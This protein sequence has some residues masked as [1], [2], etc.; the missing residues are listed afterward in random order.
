VPAVAVAAIDV[1][2]SVFVG[3]V[4]ARGDVTLSGP[5]PV[6]GTVVTLT[7]SDPA[8]TVAGSTTIGEGASSGQFGVS[9]RAVTT[10]TIVTISG[11]AGGETRSKGIRIIPAGSGLALL[12]PQSPFVGWGQSISLMA[13]SSEPAPSAGLL[14]TLTADG[15]ALTVPSTLTIPGGQTTASV[16]VTARTNVETTVTVT[17]SVGGSTRSAAIQLLP[18]FIRIDST[19][20]DLV[21]QGRSYRIEPGPFVFGGDL[22]YNDLVEV[23]ANSTSTN[24]WSVGMAPPA[25]QPLVPGVY[26]DA[27]RIPPIGSMLPTLRIAGEGRGCNQSTGEFEV[28]EAVFG[29]SVGGRFRT[30]E[31]FRATFKQ[32][33]DGSTG[34]L[35]GEIRLATIPNG[36]RV[37]RN[38]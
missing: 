20:G 17:G 34:S 27:R 21:A 16:N 9:T 8:A 1:N 11:S 3:G 6:G 13:H 2:P 26:R 35:T 33:C 22:Q 25:G 18:V 36:C 10:E 19:S 7:S 31:R 28:L 12:T 4:N 15:S 23:S 37:T 32:T 5:A 38:C 29:P 30:L 14:V 24:W